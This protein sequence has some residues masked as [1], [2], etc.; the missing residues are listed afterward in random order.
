VQQHYCPTLLA[1][2]SSLIYQNEFRDTFPDSPVPNESTI[3]HLVYRFRDTGSVQDRNRYGRPSVLS[4][5]N[6]DDIR[7]PL[8]RS[9]HFK[10]LCNFVFLF[11]DFNVIHVLTNRTCVMNGLRDFSINLFFFFVFTGP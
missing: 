5:D 6:M 4:D 7:Q 3:S 2:C 8:L 1:S 11:C 9:G 10:H